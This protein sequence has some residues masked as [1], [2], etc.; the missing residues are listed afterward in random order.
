MR[1]AALARRV[2]LSPRGK[3]MATPSR[4]DRALASSLTVRPDTD[5]ASVMGSDADVALS[6]GGVLSMSLATLTRIANGRRPRSY[7]YP[8]TSFALSR[9]S[10]AR[11][12]MV[13]H[14]RSSAI[15]GPWS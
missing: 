5:V 15:E 6:V 3:T 4:H 9:G 14:V 11:L 8:R 10:R 1:G 13:S 7:R 12:T 2:A